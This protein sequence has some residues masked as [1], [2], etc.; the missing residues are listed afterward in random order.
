M[1]RCLAE[2]PYGSISFHNN[3]A[4]KPCFTALR[5]LECSC[6]LAEGKLLDYAVHVVYLSKMYRVLTV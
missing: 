1:S 4:P 2:T 6:R 3:H 5:V